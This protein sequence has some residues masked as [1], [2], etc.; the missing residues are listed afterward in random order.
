VQG[1]SVS[2]AE[3][4]RVPLFA[5]LKDE[6]LGWVASRGE[7]VRLESG[8]VVARQ[9]DPPDGF[10]VVLD[11]ETCW[12]R[13]VGGE[14]VH[15]VTLGA[16]EIFAELILLTDAPYPTTGRAT[17]DVRLFK[18][19]PAAFW[20]MLGVCPEVLKG[21]VRVAV[22]R[23][24]IH[25]SVSQSQARLI[26]LGTL[27]AGLAHELNNPAS[28]ARRATANA[29][30]ALD[31]TT[32]RAL[33]LGSH[34][35]TQQQ[36]GFLASLPA[37]VAERA[38]ASPAL[39]PLERGDR[40]DEVA[41]W[42]EEHGAQESWNLSPTLVSA[43]L[44]AGWLDGVAD[45]LP[46]ETLGNALAW[47]AARLEAD[48]LL[49]EA[50]DGTRRVS[51]LVGAVEEYT[52]MDEAP[53]GEVDVREGLENTLKVLG[54]KLEGLEVSRDYGEDLPRITAYGGELNGAW[55]ALVDNAADAASTADGGGGGH[56]RVR[57]V[58][59]DG[60][61]LVEIVDDGPGVP[62]EV[63][64]RIFEPFF[65]TKDVGAVGLGLDLARRAVLRHGGDIRFTSRPGETRFRVRLPLEGR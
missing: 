63:R 34:A 25:E 40:E 4:R 23:S 3:L 59:E 8:S 19:E 61:V 2:S 33:A 5:G 39:D 55:T 45:R 7:E 30:A 24:Q 6:Q 62:E 64:D 16:G 9:D 51:E 11:G 28:A 46:A 15:A 17:T 22:E 27:A 14:E 13:R 56:V 58:R 31:T 49:R 60:W 65:S 32:E 43:G 38:D 20:E 52:H 26:S 18:L 12:T 48:A 54:H 21:I 42:L 10:Y 41:L 35:L 1:I 44:D 57:A 37:G 47:L 53:L 50:E 29:R 36:S